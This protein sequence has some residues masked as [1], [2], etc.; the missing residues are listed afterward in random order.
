MNNISSDRMTLISRMAIE[1]A[2]RM[3][4]DD[5]LGSRLNGIIEKLDVPPVRL[6]LE[7]MSDHAAARE[8]A[9]AVYRALL[10]RV[11]P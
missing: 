8:L 11:G 4:E 5:G 10:R 1:Y 2:H 9:A 7:L 6:S 3:A